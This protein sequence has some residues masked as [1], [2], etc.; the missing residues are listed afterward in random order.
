MNRFHF[1]RAATAVAPIALMATLSGCGQGTAPASGPTPAAEAP[2]ST[3]K[4]VLAE[5]SLKP[6]P[7]VGKA[8][9]ITFN[10]ENAGSMKHEFVVI[11]TDKKASQLLKGDEADEKGAVDELEEIEPGKS[12]KLAVDLKP[13]H[14]ALICN[15]P[16]HYMPRGMPGMLADF[17]VQ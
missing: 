10:V 13:G 2:Q 1:R 6:A 14:Y 3:V 7:G 9:R 4:V 8:G 12:A 15:L 17:T 16:G 11:K 5:Y